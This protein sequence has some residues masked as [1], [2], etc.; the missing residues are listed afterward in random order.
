[1]ETL[2]SLDEQNAA[3]GE[4]LK[5]AILKGES[6][7]STLQ[8]VADNIMDDQYQTIASFNL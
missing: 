2:R 1:M 8:S 5:E 6:L 7:L 3:E 4:R